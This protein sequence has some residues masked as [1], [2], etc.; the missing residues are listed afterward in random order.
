MPP[1]QK[2]A[3]MRRKEK[4]NNN[5]NKETKIRTANVGGE[6]PYSS[7]RSDAVSG[8]ANTSNVYMHL[9]G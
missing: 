9:F 5:N 1:E 3:L 7:A 2:V 4:K 6:S 8:K